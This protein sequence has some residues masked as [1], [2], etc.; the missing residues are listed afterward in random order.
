MDRQPN[1]III[2]P[3][4]MRADAMRHMGNPAA[5]TPNLDQLA[6]EGVSFS[7]AACQNPVCVPSRC[8]FL[9][10]L[11]PHT[12]GHRTMGF[13]LHSEEENLFSDMKKAGYYTISS[14]RGDFMAGQLSAYHKKWIDEYIKVEKPRERLAAA[15]SLRGAPDSDTYFSFYNGIIPANTRDQVVPNMDDLTIDGAI[16]SIQNR[17]RGKPFFMFVGLMYP[18][19]P[20]Q[21]EQ[22]YYDLIDKSKL[23]LRR[24]NIRPGDNKPSMEQGLADALRVKDWNEDRMDELRAVYLG[25]CAKVDDQ[26]GRVVQALKAEHIYD[27]TIILFFSDHG[28]YTGDYGIVEKAQNCFPECLVNVPLLIKPQK[29]VTTDCGINEQLVELTDICATVA[30]FSNIDIQRTTFS[31]SLRETIADKK[32]VHREF[33]CCEGGRL[34][35][36]RHCMEYDERHFDPNDLYAPRQLLQ[37]RED[38]THGK[39][40]MIRSQEYKYVHRLYED[41]EFYVLAEG[42]SENQS[43]NPAYQQ[44]IT[45][46]KLQLLD[47]YMKTCDV[48]PTKLDERFTF[49]F[50]RNNMTA[51]GLP[52]AVSA[53]IKLY[54]TISRKTAGQFID[55]M[56]RKAER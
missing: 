26:L 40:V 24:H 13:M 25:M 29:G 7:H 51:M 38:G 39:A 5:Y 50:L 1:V 52:A 28:D 10:G 27:D 3:D 33:I 56:R 30:D 34:I 19:P 8:S 45:Q 20:Y 14:T 16:R 9:T 49:E 22:K 35:G 32:T 21:V 31:K 53:M 37:A 36:E 54:L 15:P 23:P 11:Y 44:Q 48:V 47:W 2:N 18:H 55:Q 17:P 42:E 43:K 12:M 6:K 46:M 4:Q 41:D